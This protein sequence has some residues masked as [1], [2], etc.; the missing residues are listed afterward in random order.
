M[1]IEPFLLASAL[2]FVS[3]QR[4]ARLNCTHCKQ[5]YVPPTELINMLGAPHSIKFYHSLGCEEC[6]HKGVKGRQGIHE[7]LVVTKPIQELILTTPTDDQ[8]NEVAI[9]EG[10]LTLKQAAL[11]KVYEGTISVEEALR[12]AE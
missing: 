3:A 2:K 11:Q 4:L 8:I 12:L 6:N 7:V 5:E 10:M 9:K 1:G